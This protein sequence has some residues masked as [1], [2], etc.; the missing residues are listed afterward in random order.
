[1]SLGEPIFFLVAQSLSLV[2]PIFFAGI[3]LILS[4]KKGY[5]AYLNLPVDLYFAPNRKRLFGDN[6]T[7]RG[8]LIYVCGS[9]IVCLVLS[10][11]YPSYP[12]LIHQLYSF[13]PLRIGLAF[14]LSYISG[15]LINSFIK[16]RLN[17][18]PGVQSGGRLQKIIDHVDGILFVSIMLIFFL[19]IALI[20]VAVAVVIG[21][22]LH[23]LTD[24]VM[25]NIGLK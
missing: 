24:V 7:W 10:A 15:E 11:L 16:R 23:L 4:I 20:Y 5:L 19:N 21:V 9:I 2:L 25:K 6:K 12:W 17:I 22:F 14:S 1:M 13:N 8:V 3:F 18:P